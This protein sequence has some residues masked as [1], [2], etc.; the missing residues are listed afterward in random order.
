[1]LLPLQGDVCRVLETQGVALGWE[2]VAL[3]A[4]DYHNMLSA[5]SPFA[6]QESQNAECR[7]SRPSCKDRNTPKPE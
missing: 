2:Q 4:R 3:S 6:A 7:M 5:G 1:M